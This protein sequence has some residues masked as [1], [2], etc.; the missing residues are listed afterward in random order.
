MKATDLLKKQHARV[1]KL[2]EELG[3]AEDAGEKEALLEELADN[4]AAH[5]TIEEQ[6][7]YPAIYTGELKES[8]GEAVEEHLAMKR[9][10]VD[11]M[12]MD[13]DDESFDAK[14]TVLEEQ[15]QHHVDEEEKEM[16][17][18]VDKLLSDA[19][20]ELLGSRMQAMFESEMDDVPREKL[21]GQTGEAA[22]LH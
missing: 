15:K 17:P 3:E 1:D 16:F 21:P 12:S 2:F 19:E 8:L 10:L 18:L 7:F 4:L 11:L 22:P 6:L 20:L 14:L 9:L 5:T 13:A